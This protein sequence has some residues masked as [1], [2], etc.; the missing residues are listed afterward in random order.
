MKFQI[1]RIDSFHDKIYG[2]CIDVKTSIIINEEENER[3]NMEYWGNIVHFI[4]PDDDHILFP[5]RAIFNSKQVWEPVWSEYTYDF[6]TDLFDFPSLNKS[7]TSYGFVHK[8]FYYDIDAPL[9][10]EVRRISKYIDEVY[11]HIRYERD[12]FNCPHRYADSVFLITTSQVKSERCRKYSDTNEPMRKTVRFIVPDNHS[13]LKSIVT[14]KEEGLMWE[15]NMSD[16]SFD[17][18][19]TLSNEDYNF[20]QYIKILAL[21]LDSMKP[22][23]I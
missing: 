18:R 8:G 20:P 2:P 14:A 4:Y 15:P 5:I 6:I 12:V 11:S 10:F 1:R 21:V 3:L 16:F 17:C 23:L 9:Q 22:S 7:T 13:V 19:T